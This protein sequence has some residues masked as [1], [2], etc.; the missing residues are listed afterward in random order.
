[1]EDDFSL[2]TSNLKHYPHFD[3]PISLKEVKKL[4]MNEEGVASNT[5]YP[6]FLFHEEWQPYRPAGEAKPDKKSR[7]IRYGARRDAY[8]FMYYRRKLSALYEQQLAE[9]GISDCP[10]A[11]RKIPK[12]GANSGNKCNIDFAKDAF[13][14]VDRLD[15]C[16]AVALDIKGYFENLS[17]SRIK[18]VW[19]DLLGVDELPPDHYA[20]FKNI[21]KY[22]FVDQRLAYRRLGYF[23]SVQRGKHVI[24]GFK[25]PRR[26]IPKQ[27]C[28]PEDFRAKICGGD[29]AL[30]SLV[31]KNELPRGVPQ[32]API[33]DLI[34]NF[35]LIDFDAKLNR[36]A[37]ERGGRYMRYS[38]DILL[39]IPGGE[40]E[41]EAA[42]K[43]A[44]N[45]IQNHGESLE[46]NEEKTCCV[47]FTRSGEELDYKHLV[48]PQGS[49]GLEYLGFRYDGKRVYVRESTISRLYRKVS[50]AA[51]RAGARHVRANPTASLATLIDSFNY[52]LFSQRFSRVK[53]DNLT[54]DYRSWTFHSYLKRAARTFGTKGDRILPQAR[55]LKEQMR[56][57][58]EKAI[59]RAHAISNHKDR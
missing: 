39:I 22:R 12:P 3:A 25:V 44:T 13:D 15:N 6:F 48:G 29:P 7:P 21:T 57:R 8:I 38:D 46:I 36:Y 28:S 54:D 49:N 53:K 43:F 30:S 42:M 11:Y 5:F 27:L 32:G 41:A 16:V 18:S 55:N 35:Y 19:C 56:A 59:D 1:M 10:I 58:V 20:V 37:H 2:T 14:E 34:A 31:I 51:K 23:G 45:E 52:S 17:H 33:S 26:E 40:A 24:E 4:V 50:I 9:K 47:K